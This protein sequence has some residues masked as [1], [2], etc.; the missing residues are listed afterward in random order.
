M[1]SYDFAQG[2]FR[3]ALLLARLRDVLAVA[4]VAL[5]M[6]PLL[7]WALTS[8]KI[9]ADIFNK[10]HEVWVFTPTLG[11]YA[12]LLPG[13]GPDQMNAANAFRDSLL[14]ACGATLISLMAGIPAAFGLSRYPSRH[15]GKMLAAILLFRF[16]PPIALIV[17]VVQLAHQTGLFDT[18]LMVM[19]MHALLN[20]PVAV[21]MMKSFFDDVPTEIDDAAKLDGA[22]GFMTMWK[23]VLPMVRGGIAATAILC[24][25]FSW[26]EFLMALFLTVSF[27]TLPVQLS[28]LSMGAWG[29]LAA[30][31]TATL[32]PCFLFILLVQKGL[33]RGLMLGMQK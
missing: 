9:P 22:S 25:I 15:K 6:F 27:R 29:P 5:F 32:I 30:M 8:F 11:N 26:A 12:M 13:V 31:A 16:L 21:L 18:R 24:F 3:A 10:D 33:V 7:W 1:P 14:I 23:I 17:P 19:L 20:L 4:V 28:I 2:R